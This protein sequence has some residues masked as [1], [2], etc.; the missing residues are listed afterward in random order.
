MN[1]E[2]RFAATTPALFGLSIGSGEKSTSFDGGGGVGELDLV[3]R[4]DR[5]P[6]DSRHKSPFCRILP[7]SCNELVT[8]SESKCLPLTINGRWGPLL[9][10]RIWGYLRL[11]MTAEKLKWISSVS[12]QAHMLCKVIVLLQELI[13][14]FELNFKPCVYLFDTSF[15]NQKP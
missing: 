1:Q 8:P 15:T 2:L 7:S 10:W 14:Y 6:T 11:V 13:V 4:C 3:S 12:I 9:D 5:R